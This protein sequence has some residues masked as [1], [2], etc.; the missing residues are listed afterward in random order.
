RE[1]DQFCRIRAKTI[2]IAHG[3][4]RLDLHVAPNA[5]ACLLQ[6][7]Q[8]GSVTRA[9][10]YVVRGKGIEHP[11]PSHPL[12]RSRRQRPRGRA[13]APRDEVAPSDHSI[14][15]SARC[16]KDKGTSI[17][18]AFAVFRLITSSYLTGAWTGSSRGFAPLRMRSTYVAASRNK[19]RWS[20]P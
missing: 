18:S 4:A 10:P 2:G 15:S 12:L 9:C 3:P 13:A 17:P 16:W 8:K 7:L 20:L 19:S 6:A 14:T 5:P 11:D 1:C